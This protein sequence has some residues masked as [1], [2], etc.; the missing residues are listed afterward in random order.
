MMPYY[1]ENEELK[2]IINEINELFPWERKE[3]L[4]ALI[5]DF[6]DK[7]EIEIN[8]F[9]RENGKRKTEVIIYDWD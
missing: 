8:Q 5:Q 6:F 4:K 7:G 3:L 1:T 2:R 9:L